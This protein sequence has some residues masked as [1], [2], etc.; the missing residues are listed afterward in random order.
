VKLFCIFVRTF[1]RVVWPS[2]VWGFRYPFWYLQTLLNNTYIV[3]I[4][5]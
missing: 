5:I 4:E 1:A 3:G 2:S